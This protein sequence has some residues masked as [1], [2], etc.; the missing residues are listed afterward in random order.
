M[1]DGFLQ[2]AVPSVASSDGETLIQHSGS[3]QA[4][5]GRV[6]MKAA[7]AREFAREAINLSGVV[8]ARSVSGRSG[9]SCSAGARVER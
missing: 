5:G 3:I 8:E 1:G 4:A 2:V 6:E 7:T 9:P